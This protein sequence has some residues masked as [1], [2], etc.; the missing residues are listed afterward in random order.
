MKI[1]ATLKEIAQQVFASYAETK[2]QPPDAYQGAGGE[3]AVEVERIDFVEFQTYDRQAIAKAS[4]V[5][6]FYLQN[7]NIDDAIETIITK[8]KQAINDV[9][10]ADLITI[11]IE[12]VIPYAFTKAAV[13]V[14][15]SCDFEI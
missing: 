10:S 14:K 6:I 13:L 2:Y 7:E 11:N 9:A 4:G 8:I 15:L 5:I 1:Y 3:W 12:Q